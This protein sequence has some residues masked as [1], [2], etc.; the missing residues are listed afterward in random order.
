M[1]SANVPS[2]GSILDTIPTAVIE[3]DHGSLVYANQAAR[4]LFSLD[5]W[6]PDNPVAALGNAA[7]VHAL[8]TTTTTGTLQ[9]VTV[10]VHDS[11]VQCATSQVPGKAVVTLVATDITSVERVQAMRRDFVANASHELKTPVTGILAL[12]E[13]LELAMERDPVRA[14]QMVHRIRK[15]A[16]RLSQLVRELLDL[17]RIEEGERREGEGFDLRFICLDQ[18]AR[19]GTLA[20][21]LHVTVRAD[22]PDP[23]IVVGSRENMKTIVSN[24][25]TNAVKYNKPGG[26]VVITAC[27]QPTRIEIVVRDTGLGIAEEHLDRIFERFYRVD[28][29]RSREAGG[30]GLGLSI[31]RHA[32]EQM[33]GTITVESALGQG[34]RF[35]V[36]IPVEGNDV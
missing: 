11:V 24:L 8:E 16:V 26:E 20:E 29:A 2:L 31:V 10:E 25:L 28:Q 17:N 6:D 9:E 18:V 19:I 30:T 7:L 13:S 3:F 23:I 21:S 22:I 15:E 4:R 14:K 36:H 27:R 1:N 35:S 33:G 34:T 5:R 12:A 32:V